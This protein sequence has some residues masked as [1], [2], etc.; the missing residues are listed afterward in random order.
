MAIPQAIDDTRLLV[1]I[2][3]TLGVTGVGEFVEIDDGTWEAHYLLHGEV[4]EIQALKC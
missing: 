1:Q 2:S 3:S 4:L